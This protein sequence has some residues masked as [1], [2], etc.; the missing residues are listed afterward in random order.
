MLYMYY[1]MNLILKKHKNVVNV[2]LCGTNKI[3]EEESHLR[4]KMRSDKM[5]IINVTITILEKFTG[6]A[7]SKTK[8][9]MRYTW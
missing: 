3:T 5:M 6:L 4:K 9:I 8:P 2:A 1:Q 7:S